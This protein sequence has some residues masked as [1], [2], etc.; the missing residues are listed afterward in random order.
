MSSHQRDFDTVENQR[1]HEDLVIKVLDDLEVSGGSSPTGLS[2]VA[3]WRPTD[4]EVVLKEFGSFESE[5]S[6]ARGG[7]TPTEE[8]CVYIRTTDYSDNQNMSITPLMLN[9]VITSSDIEAAFQECFDQ[10]EWG[11]DATVNVT[12]DDWTG[13]ASDDVT[14]TV[15][16]SGFKYGDMQ[17]VSTTDNMLVQTAVMVEGSPGV[18]GFYL[19][20]SSV[21]YGAI[22]EKFIAVVI[23]DFVVDPDNENMSGAVAFAIFPMMIDNLI[24]GVGNLNVFYIGSMVQAGEEPDTIYQLQAAQ[25][26]REEYGT[27]IAQDQQLPAST[28]YVSA[29]NEM[30]LSEGTVDILCQYVIPPRAITTTSTEWDNNGD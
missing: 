25:S 13:A 12:G 11:P 8:T 23:E 22:I 24:S 17:S 18:M 30:I 19:D 4:D 2:A 15:T 27:L 20:L 6:I 9:G 29:G 1:A 10:A 7:D 14:W 3:T 26:G 21:P 28:S 5:M 16:G